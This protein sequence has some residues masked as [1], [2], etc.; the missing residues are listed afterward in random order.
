MLFIRVT[1]IIRFA[2]HTHTLIDPKVIIIIIIN[3]MLFY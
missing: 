1:V 2:A 3:T